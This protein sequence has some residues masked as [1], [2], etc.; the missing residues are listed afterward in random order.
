MKKQNVRGTSQTRTITLD[1][2]ISQEPVT[3]NR[4]PNKINIQDD[5]NSNEQDLSKEQD[6][7][8][9]KHIKKVKQF[10]KEKSKS[11]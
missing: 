6:D 7:I 4:I 3:D 1:R 2:D 11:F 8:I 10:Q 5:D 9:R